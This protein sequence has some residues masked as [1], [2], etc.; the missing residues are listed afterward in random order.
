MLAFLYL[1][2]GLHRV[3][4]Y[5]SYLGRLRWAKVHGDKVQSFIWLIVH[6]ADCQGM[7]TGTK[8]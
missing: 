2:F 5:I 1:R 4:S 6:E 3:K 8:M 7:H